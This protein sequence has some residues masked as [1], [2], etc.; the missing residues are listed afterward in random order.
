MRRIRVT[1]ERTD[2]IVIDV[3]R[4]GIR[5]GIWSAASAV[6]LALLAVVD[7]SSPEGFGLLAVNMVFLPAVAVWLSRW[8]HRFRRTLARAQGR[9]LL[10]GEPIEVARAE[11]RV[12]KMPL[13]RVPVGYALSLWVMTA[14]GPEDI[15]IGRFATLLEAT[16]LSGRLEDFLQRTNLKQH[17]HV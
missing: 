8:G 2:C 5:L 10:D 11:L 6:A 4:D 16:A 13:T 9:L 15:P 3:G 17:R 1:Q 12:L 14:A 7:L